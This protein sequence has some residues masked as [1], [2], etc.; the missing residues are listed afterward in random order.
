MIDVR[1]KFINAAMRAMSE[2]KANEW[3]DRLER[4]ADANNVGALLKPAS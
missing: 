2:E 3:A 1:R 4:F